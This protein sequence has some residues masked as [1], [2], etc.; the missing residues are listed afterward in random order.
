MTGLL[1]LPTGSQVRPESVVVEV[2]AGCQRRRRDRC[3]RCADRGPAG[4]RRSAGATQA[5]ARPAQTRRATGAGGAKDRTGVA[6]PHD[7]RDLRRIAAED[8]RHLRADVAVTA[9]RRPRDRGDGQHPG[10]AGGDVH[11]VGDRVGRHR[12]PAGK[13]EDRSDHLV[14]GG[15]ADG[16]CHVGDGGRVRIDRLQID[17][18]QRLLL[19]LAAGRRPRHDDGGERGNTGECANA[20]PHHMHISAVHSGLVVPL[21]STTATITDVMTTA[22]I[23]VQNHHFL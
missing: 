3:G 23:P 4:R 22:P 1:E 7:H 11:A 9:G 8:L 18:D 15:L 20:L 6:G 10:R 14:A 19:L 16:D 2:R 21:V 5:A 12:Q 17:E 13:V